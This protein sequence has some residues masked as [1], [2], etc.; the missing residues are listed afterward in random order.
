MG[1]V[2]EDDGIRWLE[3]KCFCT[4]RKGCEGCTFFKHKDT[5]SKHVFYIYQTKIVE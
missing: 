1:E 5:V 3:E 2:K 4:I